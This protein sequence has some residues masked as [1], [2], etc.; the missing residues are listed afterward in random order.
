MTARSVRFA[1]SRLLAVEINNDDD[2]DTDAG[3]SA[4]Q[5]QRICGGCGESIPASAPR[6]PYCGRKGGQG[7]FSTQ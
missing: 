2:E 7:I 3:R 1:A 6:C 4:G 5:T